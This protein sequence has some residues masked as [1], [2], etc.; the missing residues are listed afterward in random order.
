[1]NTEERQLA[2]VL[3][4]ITP[5]PPRPVT[6]EQVAYRLVSEPRLGRESRFGREQRPSRGRGRAW[7]PVM[8]AA[9]VIVIASAL[10][11]IP[12]DVRTFRSDEAPRVP[13]PEETTAALEAA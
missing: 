7:A 1:V 5:E 11:L 2:D 6:V 12:R 10:A 13:V 8:A 4:R 3:H 9:A